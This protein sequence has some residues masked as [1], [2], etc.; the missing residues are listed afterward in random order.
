MGKWS[1]QMI[2]DLP[3]GYAFKYTLSLLYAPDGKTYDGVGLE[4]DVEVTIDSAQRDRA[5]N[6]PTPEA[7]VAGDVQLR[8]AAELVRR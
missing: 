6:A 5:M 3:N 8:T 4:P 2:D 7:R 1:V